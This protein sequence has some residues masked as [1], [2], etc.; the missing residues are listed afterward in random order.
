MVRVIWWT[1]TS[2][3]RGP[4]V[5]R[6]C[7]RQGVSKLIGDSLRGQRAFQALRLASAYLPCDSWATKKPSTCSTHVRS[8]GGQFLPNVPRGSAL[9]RHDYE[10]EIQRRADHISVS[11]LKRHL[12]SAKGI[13]APVY[14]I[15]S[16]SPTALIFVLLTARSKSRSASP[17][18]L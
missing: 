2:K 3:S 17:F 6:V 10:R 7:R 5:S 15:N 4:Q 14:W 8:V 18:L 11:V 13:R 1:S 16:I 9:L 12:F